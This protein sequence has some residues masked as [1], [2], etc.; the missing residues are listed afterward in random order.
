[1]YTS[2]ISGLGFYVPEHVVTNDDLSKVMDT[3]DAW[4]QER[5]GIKERRHI[6]PGDGNTTSVMGTKAARIAI[7]RA[8]I[9]PND[10]ELIIFA[11][12]SPDMYFPGGG[13]QVQDQLGIG[14]VPAL[15]VRNQCSGFVYALSTADQYIKTGMY[16]NVLVIGS[17]NH[18]GGLDMTTRGRG[19]SVIFGDG[20]GAAVVSRNETGT[21]GI[22]STH[23]H[24]EG[25]HKDELALQGPSTGYWVPQILEENPQED[26][27]YFPYMNGQFVFKNAVVRFSEVIQEGLKANG[28]GV[29]DI[30]MLIPHQ[31]N[32]RISQFIQKKFGL[33]DEQ[34]FNNIQ[35][36]GN[37]TAASIPIALTEAWEAG[38]IKSGD[39]V[40]LAAF[41][42][43]FTWGSAII[44]WA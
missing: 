43:G 27:P 39:L 16:K 37:T 9:D 32:L 42:S 17:E 23:L 26:I 15:D 4:I 3:N 21:G 44:R 1:M 18:S 40:V 22:L 24:S 12:L 8:E 10:I 14:T 31:A 19:V 13:V 30:A 20:A 36:Y 34:V 6:L 38:K 28:L 41:G 7:E 2:R 25:K 33:A 5:T 11:T 29:D 35:K